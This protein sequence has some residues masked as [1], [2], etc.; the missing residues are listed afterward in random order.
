M[1]QFL[2]PNTQSVHRTDSY[3]IVGECQ[4]Y[5][6]FDRNHIFPY[7]CFQVLLGFPYL[8]ACTEGFIITITTMTRLP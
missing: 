5:L 2:L 3:S 8:C 7:Y 4:A 1:H 6:L